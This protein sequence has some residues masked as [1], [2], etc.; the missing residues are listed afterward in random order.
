MGNAA[1]LNRTIVAIV[2]ARNASALGQRF[3]REIARDLGA[4]DIA[5]A[6][7]LARG[8]DTAAH[9]GS[10]KTGTIAVMAGSIDVVYPPE[11]ASL[12]REIVIDG[13]AVSEMPF[14]LQRS[15]NISPA[16]TGSSPG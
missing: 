9:K 6:S 16:A 7:G 2:G 1:I 3:A 5:V 15:P 13:A 10:L 8:S 11:N 4:A 14:A 12:Y